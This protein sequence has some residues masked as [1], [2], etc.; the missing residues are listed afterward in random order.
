M[1]SPFRKL[2]WGVVRTSGLTL[3]LIGSTAVLAGPLEDR[4]NASIYSPDAIVRAAPQI[5]LGDSDV[6]AI[7]QDALRTEQSI[8]TLQRQ[9]LAEI[10]E[11]G[12][13]LSQVPIDTENVMSGFERLLRLEDSIKRLRF[14]LW[15]RTNNRLSAD[16]R[17][18][19][20]GEG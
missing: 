6:D 4:I 17:R 14:E 16:Q 15:I 11:I 20:N 5:G 8:R 1:R 7:K 3:T 12:R 9:A 2:V 19:L 13:G 18:A 10:D